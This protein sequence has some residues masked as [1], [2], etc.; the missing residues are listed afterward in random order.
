MSIATALLALDAQRDALA[1]N[2]TAK[3]VISTTDE[4]LTQLV[5]KVAN[6]ATSGGV[7]TSD[8]TATA[9]DIVEGKTAYVNGVKLV[10]THVCQAGGN[11][12]LGDV[13]TNYGSSNVASWVVPATAN[14]GDFLIGYVG[15]NYGVSGTASAGWSL[16]KS[17]TGTYHNSA[18]F[19][20]VCDVSD[21]GQTLTASLERGEPWTTI[22][23]V[24]SGAVELTGSNCTRATGGTTLTTGATANT[25]QGDLILLLGSARAGSGVSSFDMGTVKA[26]GNFAALK[27]TLYSTNAVVAGAMSGTLSHSTGTSGLGAAIVTIR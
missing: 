1:T 11:A 22:C 26:S 15:S 16:L 13:T 7:D 4:T 6:I 24:V 19:Y 21:I 10:G 18:I 25:G 9:D 8:A 23:V 5:T 20:K 17:A 12:A 2:L 3:G 14:V 27:S